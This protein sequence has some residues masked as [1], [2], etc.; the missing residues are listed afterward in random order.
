MR[1]KDSREL[2]WQD[3]LGSAGFDRPEDEWARRWAEAYVDFAAGEKRA[4]LH[5]QGVRFFPVVGWAERGGYLADGHGNSVP[6]FHVTWG[7]GPAI[8]APFARRIREAGNRVQIR[9]RHR[10][11][12]LV[13][14]AGTVT[15]VRGAILEPSTAA[16]GTA[17]LRVV[18]GDFE[19][20]AQAVI[21]TTGGIGGNH[22]L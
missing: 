21:V 11:D 4:W 15:G 13:T 7:T 6:R 5:A 16:R 2:A 19:L 8:V 17:S 9:F 20:T 12:E 22:D 1:I 18:T 14:A 3:W 10:V